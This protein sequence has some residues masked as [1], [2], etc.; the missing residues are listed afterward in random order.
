MQSIFMTKVMIKIGFVSPWNILTR[1]K[2]L[3]DFEKVF[4]FLDI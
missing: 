4:S 3:D 1:T 2:I